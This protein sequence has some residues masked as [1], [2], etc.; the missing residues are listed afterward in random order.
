MR[1]EEPFRNNGL[2]RHALPS[3]GALKVGG[4]SSSNIVAAQMAT[5]K[6]SCLFMAGIHRHC[7][8]KH[9]AVSLNALQSGR[10]VF[11][12]DD[13]LPMTVQNE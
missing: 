2:M 13:P 4:E 10:A 1:E 5:R 8:L 12:S 7:R 11:S 3:A 9:A 6:H